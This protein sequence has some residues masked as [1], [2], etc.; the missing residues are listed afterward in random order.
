MCPA[1]SLC[2]QPI[3]EKVMNLT[4]IGVSEYAHKLFTPSRPKFRIIWSL[5]E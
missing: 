5:L 2:L 3:A 1:L 4:I